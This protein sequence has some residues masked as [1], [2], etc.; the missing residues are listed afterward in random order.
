[1][2]THRLITISP[3][4]GETEDDSLADLAVGWQGDQIKIG[5]ITRSERLAKYNRL[6]AIEA[7][8]RFPVTR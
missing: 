4:R 5:S 7:E 6:L 2:Q 8:T 3:R 1:M